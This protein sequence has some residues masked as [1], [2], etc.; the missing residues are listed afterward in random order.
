[1]KSKAPLLSAAA[2]TLLAVSPNASAQGDE[3]AELKEMVKAMQQTIAD[4]NALELRAQAA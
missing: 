3:M 1:M 4:Q 2:A